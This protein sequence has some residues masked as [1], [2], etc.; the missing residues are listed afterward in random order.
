MNYLAALLRLGWLTGHY[1]PAVVGLSCE[2]MDENVAQY[3]SRFYM[4]RLY[5]PMFDHHIAISA[6]VAGELREAS[7]GHDVRRGVWVRPM[8]AEC[9]LF[10]PGRCDPQKRGWLKHLTG[11]REG[12]YFSC[13]SGGLCRRRILDYY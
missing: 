10:H 5:F 13:T 7:R 6:H 2:R 8:G 12:Q 11:A 3:I 9:D 4:R 1:R